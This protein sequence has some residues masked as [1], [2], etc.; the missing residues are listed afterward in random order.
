VSAWVSRILARATFGPAG[1]HEGR[2]TPV[3]SGVI[4]RLT[5]APFT[6]RNLVEGPNGRRLLSVWSVKVVGGFENRG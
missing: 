6:V 5:N 2:L 4:P 1:I 3:F